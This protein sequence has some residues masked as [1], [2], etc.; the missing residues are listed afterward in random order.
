MIGEDPISVFLC[1]KQVG[2]S[3]EDVRRQIQ[4]FIKSILACDAFLG[5]DIPALLRPKISDDHLSIE[6]EAAERANVIAMLL[7]SPGTIAELTAFVLNPQ[8][9]PKLLVFNELKYKGEK[10]FL[11]LGP[12][13]LL[14][15]NSLIW[16][17]EDETA[18]LQVILASIDLRAAQCLLSRRA[19]SK[20]ALTTDEYI[21]LLYVHILHPIGYKDLTSAIPLAS[22]QVDMAL[23][24]LFSYKVLKKSDNLYWTVHNWMDRIA[25]S[26]SER[27]EIARVRLAVMGG[28]LVDAEARKR[29]RLAAV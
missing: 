27:A 29:Y 8:L 1:G 18:A 13:K 9:R 11:N 17:P 23:R 10:T 5:E 20:L 24:S 21:T 12:L 19:P 4:W 3:T 2:R 14:D 26:G 6:T 15:D 28:E 25:L 16:L 22:K 7:G